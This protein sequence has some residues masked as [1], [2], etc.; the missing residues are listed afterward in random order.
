MKELS[1]LLIT[2]EEYSIFSNLCYYFIKSN[3]TKYY[4][5]D[6]YYSNTFS[7]LNYDV[8]NI[9]TKNIISKNFTLRLYESIKQI[10]SKY[11]FLIQEDHWYIDKWIDK[12]N[13]ETILKVM[14]KHNLS[15]VKM[16]PHSYIN[17]P[18]INNDDIY[19]DE[20]ITISWAGGC[21]YP[22]SHHSTIFNKNYLLSNLE[23][24][25][26]N[27]QFTPWQ[28]EIFNFKYIKSI[29]KYN[30]DNNLLRAAYIKNIN[31]RGSFYSVVKKGKLNEQGFRILKNSEN[32]DEVKKLRKLLPSTRFN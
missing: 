11:I 20:N 16:H 3:I 23:E 12:N 4:D 31:Y 29:K 2:C 15:Q 9:I 5:C 28:Q 18:C 1:I 8:K 19:C 30:N 24:S 25:I 7:E 22:I 17:P 13:I 14:S 6:V 21:D 26:Q 27:E 32:I 10:S